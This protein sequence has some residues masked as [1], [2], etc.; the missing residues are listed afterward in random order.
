MPKAITHDATLG[1]TQKSGRC[2]ATWNIS[3]SMY[4][5]S[6]ISFLSILELNPARYERQTHLQNDHTKYQ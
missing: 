1:F 6:H 5:M 2:Y 4:G 3:R